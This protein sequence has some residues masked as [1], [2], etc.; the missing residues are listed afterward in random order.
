MGGSFPCPA[1]PLTPY[2]PLIVNAALTGMV[3]R[4]DSVPHVPLTA[5]EIAADA[6]RCF[7]AGAT[8]VHLHARDADARPEWRREAYAELI[9]EI[10]RRCPGI[11]VCATTS[12]RDVADVDRRGDVSS[13]TARRGRTWPASRWGR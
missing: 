10:R 11:V 13:S 2:A 6:E 5:A 8:V 3:A 12:G 7:A 4:R 9:P 1:H